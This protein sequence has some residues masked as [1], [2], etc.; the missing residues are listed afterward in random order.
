MKS[1]IIGVIISR[2]YKKGY[3][4]GDKIP[5]KIGQ[6]DNTSNIIYGWTQEEYLETGDIVYVEIFGYRITKFNMEVFEK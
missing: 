4:K 3:K 6:V 1:K 2:S 5:V